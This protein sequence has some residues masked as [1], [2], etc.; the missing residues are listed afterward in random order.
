MGIFRGYGTGGQAASA[1]VEDAVDIAYDP[2]TSGLTATDV[3]AAIDEVVVSLGSVGGAGS[4]LAGLIENVLDPSLYSQ[5]GNIIATT[6]K[7]S[8]GVTTA[9]P[10][11]ASNFELGEVYAIPVSVAQTMTF[12][13]MSVRG[14]VGYDPATNGANL[15][16]IVWA[17]RSETDKRPGTVVYDSGTFEHRDTTSIGSAADLYL[18]A[19]FSPTLTLEAGK[20]YWVGIVTSLTSGSW[21]SIRVANPH[22]VGSAWHMTNDNGLASVFRL[23]GTGNNPSVQTTTGFDS[24]D[25]GTSFLPIFNFQTA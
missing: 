10:G 5:A 22:T 6:F 2:A 21:P 4:G 1:G 3:Q 14:G 11:T 19:N 18:W 8:S 9:I 20:Q 25:F 16:Y 24:S 17:E 23:N 13:R 7:A 15:R 12:T